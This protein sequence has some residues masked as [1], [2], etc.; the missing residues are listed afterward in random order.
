MISCIVLSAGLSS[1]FGSPKALAN[2]NGQTVM[3][4]LLHSFVSSDL[5]EIIIVLGAE[6]ERIKPY[7][8]KHKKVKVVYN[9]DYN[10]GQTSSFQTG[11]RYASKDAEGIML[12]PVDFPAIKTETINI[13]IKEFYLE[14]SK[15]IIPQYCS[16]KGHPPVFPVLLKDEFLSLK[17]EE[18][19]NAI[20]HRHEEKIKFVEVFDSSV[21][22]TFNT[23]QEL[24]DLIGN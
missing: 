10:F 6:A 15:I 4:Y 17:F 11:L 24:K 12:L 19:L 3:E 23:V 2:L 7:I 22:Q 1:R 9:K 20:Q 13:L 5:D 8:L 14:S 18:G 16:R 21:I